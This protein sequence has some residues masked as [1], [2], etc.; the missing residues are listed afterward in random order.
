MKIRTLTRWHSKIGILVCAW[1]LLL[2]T[3]GLMLQHSHRLGLDKPVLTESLWYAVADLPVPT[4]Q[5]VVEHQLYQVDNLLVTAQ[6]KIGVLDGDLS[7][8]LAGAES[9]LASD[10]SQ[11][12]LLTLEGELVDTIPLSGRRLA[13]VSAEGLPLLSDHSGALWQLDWWLEQPPEVSELTVMTPAAT[14]SEARLP[15]GLDVEGIGVSVER[16]LLSLHSGR[17]FGAVGEWLMTI[18]AL[19]AIAI[20]CTG[21]VI[22]GRRR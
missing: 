2:A 17:I 4:V 20:A 3:T 16:L 1:I 7:G 11:L 15:E 12:W 5:G 6:G 8:V 19:M 13:G 9:L 21:F 14:A 10:Q 18:V 22:W